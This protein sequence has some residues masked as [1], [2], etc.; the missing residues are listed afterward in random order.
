MTQRVLFLCT[1]NYYRSRFAELLFN[2]L[3]C[4]TGLNWEADSR[5]LAAEQ[6]WNAGP[7]LPSAL[8]VL[9]AHGVRVDRPPRFPIQVQPQDLERADLVI[10]L[11]EEEHR[12]YLAADFPG[13]EERVEYWH[14]QD[15]GFIPAQLALPAIEQ[16]VRALVQ[17]LLLAY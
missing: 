16:E 7:I 13:W 2:H 6:L 10:A 9:I 1:G 4:E 5:G 3:A 17:H 15:L 14:V 8:E 11:D 12:Q